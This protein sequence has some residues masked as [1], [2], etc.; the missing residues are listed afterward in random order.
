MTVEIVSCLIILIGLWYWSS[1]KIVQELAYQ[2]VKQHCQSLR[3][4][5]LDDYVAFHSIFIQRDDHG[6]LR[7]LRSYRFEFS[8]TGNE[9]Y[10]GTIIL[11]GRQF[12]KIQLEPYRIV[13]NE[14]SIRPD[15]L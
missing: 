1:A 15:D 10:N 6:R 14:P 7:L 4:L 11:S 5:M 13:D 8:S 3:L 2:A 12:C 9:R